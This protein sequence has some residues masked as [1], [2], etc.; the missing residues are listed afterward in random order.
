MTLSPRVKAIT[1]SASITV[2]GIFVGSELA[3]PDVTGSFMIDH[4]K[5]LVHLAYSNALPPNICYWQ[6]RL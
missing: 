3:I 5:R 1:P 6:F 4:F 2:S